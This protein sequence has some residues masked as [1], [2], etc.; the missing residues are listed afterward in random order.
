MLF[1]L[2]ISSCHVF[3][4]FGN[5]EPKHQLND[6][7]H[8]SLKLHICLFRLPSTSDR[9]ICLVFLD[10]NFTDKTSKRNLIFYLFLYV[11]RASSYWICHRWNQPLVA[12]SFYYEWDGIPLCDSHTGLETGKKQI[13]Q[14]FINLTFYISELIKLQV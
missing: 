2:T 8:S 1:S 3:L 4:F 12:K 13:P 9:F 10:A 5:V 7:C 14:T 6:S 11:C